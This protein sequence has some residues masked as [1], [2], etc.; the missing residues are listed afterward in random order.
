MHPGMHLDSPSLCSY[1]RKREELHELLEQK[2]TVGIVGSEVLAQQ[3]EVLLSG[4]PLFPLHFE[5]LQHLHIV[6]DTLM[7]EVQVK[8]LS[9]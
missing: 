5:V 1:L 4:T 9:W 8:W 2:V 3:G 6:L 7:N